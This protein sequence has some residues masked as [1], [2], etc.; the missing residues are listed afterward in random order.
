MSQFTLRGK[1]CV[2]T[3]GASGIGRA[4]C[5][6]FASEGARVVVVDLNMAAAQSVAQALGGVGHYAISAN[7]GVEM[8]LRKVINTA[9]AAVG[10]IDVF[11]GNAGIPSYGGADVP[12]DEWER[13]W[14]VNTMQHVFVARHL[15]PRWI[16]RG[17]GGH[18]V[19]TASAAGL[20]TQVGAL[21]YSVT[22][23]AS[24]AVAEWLA[25]THAEHGINVSCLCPQAVR[26][27]F[28]PGDAADAAD[29]EDGGAAGSDGILQ[30]SGVADTL[31]DAMREGRFLVLPHPE[32]HKYYQRR[33]ADTDRWL[34]G[35]SKAHHAFGK[36]SLNAPN[37]TAAKL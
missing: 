8:D 1:V 33:A 22:K 27:G 35:M 10:N 26:T 23:H 21:P 19:V 16:E 13:I 31:V 3:G 28:L 24:V 5:E 9:E 25:I 34:K 14:K 18:L 15:F 4:I 6:K 36:G 20:L 37:T 32:V 7:C 30:P 12:N 29:A 11:C 2:V 17:K